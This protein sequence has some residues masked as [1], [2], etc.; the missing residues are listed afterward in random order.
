MIQEP[1]GP[2]RRRS[3]HILADGAQDL[4]ADIDVM[5]AA[6]LDTEMALQG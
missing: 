5:S 3:S 2:H 6:A 4:R 1:H